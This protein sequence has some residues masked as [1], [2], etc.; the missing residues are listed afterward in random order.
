MYTNCH[1]FWELSVG[2]GQRV[3]TVYMYKDQSILSPKLPVT[4]VLY[5]CGYLST[6]LI[7]LVPSLFFARGGEKFPLHMRKIGWAQDYVLMA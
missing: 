5:H 1:Q 3:R 7:S 6:V 2:K 4:P